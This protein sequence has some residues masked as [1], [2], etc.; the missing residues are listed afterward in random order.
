MEIELESFWRW[1]A[2]LELVPIIKDHPRKYR[3]VA[4]NRTPATSRLAGRAADDQR[5]HIEV[6]SR[7][8]VNKILHQILSEL[9]RNNG[10][11]EGIYAGDVA[12]HLLGSYTLAGA[13]KPAAAR[14][15]AGH[16]E[17][18]ELAQSRM[19]RQLRIGPRPSRLALAQAQIVKS[20]VEQTVHASSG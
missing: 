8:I 6:L 11:V 14:V 1:F 17:P 5:A 12:R 9:H 4:R 18:S 10:V 20:A 16:D 19:P 15:R 7:G 13:I 3:R 2:G